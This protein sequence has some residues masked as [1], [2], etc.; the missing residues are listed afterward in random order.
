MLPILCSTT[1][2]R[3]APQQQHATLMKERSQPANP[4]NSVSTTT[5]PEAAAAPSSPKL[6]RIAEAALAASADPRQVSARSVGKRHG[7]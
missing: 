3:K 1:Q 5:T 6:R 7:P 2:G 4:I